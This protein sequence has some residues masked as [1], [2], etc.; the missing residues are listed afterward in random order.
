MDDDY[1]KQ[2]DERKQNVF[3]SALKSSDNLQMLAKIISVLR[4]GQNQMFRT[5]GDCTQ[6]VF[7][8]SGIRLHLAEV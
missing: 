7:W 2:I 3:L 4:E 8:I 6:V 5:S 1:L